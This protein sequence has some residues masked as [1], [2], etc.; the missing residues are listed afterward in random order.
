MLSSTLGILIGDWLW[1]EGLRLLGAKK[2][3]VVDTLKPFFAAF[4]G[5]I[6]L[7]ETIRL[8]AIGGMMLTVIGV[9]MVSIE[10]NQTT[11]TTTPDS[12]TSTKTSSTITNP[13]PNDIQSSHI[14]DT[15]SLELPP[16]HTIPLTPVNDRLIDQEAIINL[17]EISGLK[18]NPTPSFLP[19]S[20]HLT[21]K[22][23]PIF[24]FGSTGIYLLLS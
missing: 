9:L 17:S 11:T 6:L 5:W 8:P 4:L 16:T 20:K 15:D 14:G 7:G 21:S 13:S 3:L 12:T 1:L 18:S 24:G 22:S 19:S 23:H 10:P 2:V